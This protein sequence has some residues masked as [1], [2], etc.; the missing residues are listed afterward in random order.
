MY[1]PAYTYQRRRQKGREVV[2][3]VREGGK[4]G[5]VREWEGEGVVG[6]APLWRGAQLLSEAGGIEETE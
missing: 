2:V 1:D 4:V 6:V 5:V 3:V